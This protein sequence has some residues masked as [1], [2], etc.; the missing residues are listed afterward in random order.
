MSAV[1]IKAKAIAFLARREHSQKELT[2]KLLNKGYDRASIVSLLD[3]L[4][5][6][7]LQSDARFTECYVRMRKNAGFGP[8][9]IEMELKSRGIT[10]AL[11]HQYLDTL[12]PDWLDHLQYVL[13]KRFLDHQL[14]HKDWQK[15]YRFL[16]YRGF[17]SDLIRECLKQR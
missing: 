7:D 5:Q 9:R 12:S 1:S 17:P 4:V 14:T 15:A 6:Q 16:L 3:E 11:I 2:Q 13:E 8:L 10:D